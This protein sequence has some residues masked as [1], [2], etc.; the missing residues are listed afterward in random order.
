MT[1]GAHGDDKHHGP[2]AKGK[3]A[4]RGAMT[5]MRDELIG[6]NTVLSNRDKTEHSRER[7]QDSRW[8]Q[9]EQLEDHAAN[10]GRG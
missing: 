7:G 1:R 10:K 2:G 9:T 8:I 3:G 4:G 6:E 5:D